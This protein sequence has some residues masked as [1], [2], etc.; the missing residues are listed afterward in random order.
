M[1]GT[2]SSRSSSLSRTCFS[3]AAIIGGAVSRSSKS[4][5]M[6]NIQTGKLPGSEGSWPEAGHKPLAPS[7]ICLS[8]ARKHLGTNP[9]MRS[10][11]IEGNVANTSP[12]RFNRGSLSATTLEHPA[13][14]FYPILKELMLSEDT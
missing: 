5:H 10:A 9:A 14:S 7:N 13:S 8:R 11:R 6:S 12:F 3:S 4:R 1:W 2:G